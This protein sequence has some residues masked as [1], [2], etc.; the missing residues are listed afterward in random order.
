MRFAALGANMRERRSGKLPRWARADTQFVR[1]GVRIGV[2]GLCYRHT[3]SVTLA[4]HVAHLRFE[5]DSVTVTRRVPALRAASDVVIF[6]GHT[7]A[8]TDSARRAVA[9]DLVRLARGIRGVDLWLGGPS[10]NQVIDRIE[11]V[12]LM[13]AGSHGQVVAV[14][15]LVVDPVAHRV[16]ESRTELQPTFVDDVTPD[17]A[18][19]ARIERWNEAVGPIAAVPLGRSARTLMRNRGGESA[20]GN[21]VAD[22]IRAAVGSDVAFQNSGGLR[23]DLHE[24]PLTKASIYEV[25]PFENTVFTMD[26]TGAEVTLALEQ[27]LEAGRVTQVSGIRYVFDS[28]RPRGSR[29]LSVTNEGGV[30]LDPVKTYKVACNDF[31]ATGGDNYD[32]LSKGLNRTN[33]GI[34]VR[35]VLEDFV[36]ERSKGGGAVDY[37]LDGRIQRANAR[38]NGG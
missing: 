24:G 10:H 36:Q 23:A 12:P 5:D 18:M 6:V 26:L 22:A 4:K 25:M 1:R 34:T 28:S 21:L 33:T 2:L 9:G 19:L 37:R 31:M 29:V 20:L 8:E 3:P 15:D 16:I 7:P 11:D 30:P 35:E 32:V 17:P 38:R 27:A 13:I 14:C